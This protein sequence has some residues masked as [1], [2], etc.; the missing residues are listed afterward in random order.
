MKE[1]LGISTFN[2]NHGL[3]GDTV[4][5]PSATIRRRIEKEKKKKQRRIE[6]VVEREKGAAK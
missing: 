3:D 2:H 4:E 6:G 1:K 5:L